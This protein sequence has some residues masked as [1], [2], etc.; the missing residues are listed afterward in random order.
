M[1]GENAPRG[2]RDRTGQDMAY[3]V[4][5]TV[6]NKEKVSRGKRSSTVVVVEFALRVLVSSFSAMCVRCAGRRQLLPPAADAGE[7]AL[8]AR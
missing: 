1:A 4:H 5:T 7:A 2:P 6:K 8:G 3:A